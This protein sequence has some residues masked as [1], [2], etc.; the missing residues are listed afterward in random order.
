MFATLEAFWHRL[1]RRL[2]RAEWAIRHLGL[3]ASEGTSEEPGLLLIQIDGLPRRQVEA[4]MAA[5]RMPFLRRLRDHGQHPL[6][7]FYS[8]L[9]STTPA[10]QGELYYGVRAGVPAFSFLDRSL[11]EMGML[12]DSD[13]ARR[14][15]EK[16]AAQ[17]EGL[18]RDG[19][20]WSNIFSGGAAP[21]ESNFCVAHA[22]FGDTWRAGRIPEILTFFLLQLPAMFRVSCLVLLELVIGLP[23]AARGIFRGQWFSQELGMVLSRMCVGVAL[24]E[25]VNIGGKVDV[26]RGLPVV[27]VNFLGYDELAHRRGPGS[28]FAHWSLKGIDRAIQ[29]LYLAAHRSQRRDYHVW[30]FSDHGQEETHSFAMELS[31]GI[32]TVVAECVEKMLA[33]QAAWQTRSEAH[34]LPQLFRKPETKRRKLKERFMGAFSVEREK[35]FSIA[36]TGPVGHLYFAEPLDDA[37]KSSLARWLVERGNIPGVL[38]RAANGRITWY[39]ARGETAVPEGLPELLRTHP[40]TLRD[41]LAQDVVKFCEN[42]NSGDLILLGWN[43]DGSSWSFAPERGAHAGPGPDETQGFLLVPPATKLPPGA[44]NFVRPGGLRDAALDLLGRKPLATSDTPSVYPSRLRVMSYNVH[45]CIG[46][47][48]RVSPRRIARVIAQQSPDLVA[49]QELDHGRL[50][51]RGEDQASA[52]AQIL[53]YHVT[54]LATV[55]RGA[56]R[57][58]HAV[59]SRWPIRTVKVAEL[60]TRSLSIWPEPRG[61]LWSRVF[62][63]NMPI[64]V[65][66]TH[67]GLSSSER[68]AQ[69]QTLL[70]PEWLGPILDTQ[71]IVLCGDFNLP[72]GTPPYR[73][74]ADRLHDVASDG[75]DALYT[76]IS[77]RPFARID[78]IFTSSHFTTESVSV[79]RNYLTRVSSDHLPLLAD[80]H[81]EPLALKDEVKRMI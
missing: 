74:A 15:E 43:W 16:F 6:H 11:G 58:G 18:L 60:P 17:G 38:H 55:T 40:A 52:I 77:T 9:P 70:G 42:E 78:H 69:M 20:S 64:N 2:S 3:S 30:I 36:A 57:Y 35:S 14:F 56:E 75:S 81:V 29:D 27:H 59:L 46:M 80:L 7:T 73:L 49:L 66:T 54:F 31:E 37:Q 79:I 48:G 61:A 39:H 13:W 47:D 1:R 26:T 63:G 50:R 68:L 22:G 53:G 72:P 41:E 10:V 71:A 62:L 67:L 51:S 19:S 24:R 65:V 45:S 12:F 44:T 5:G 8:G 28:R 32:K 34:P 4:A 23:E 21:E 33:T 76:F 25:I